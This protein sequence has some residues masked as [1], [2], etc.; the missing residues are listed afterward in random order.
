MEMIEERLA[1]SVKARIGNRSETR[2]EADERLDNPRRGDING[3]A[4]G[5]QGVGLPPDLV[6]QGLF[7]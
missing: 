4:V 2:L 6:A 5:K 7:P 1:V 3:R